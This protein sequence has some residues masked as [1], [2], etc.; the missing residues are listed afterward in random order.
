MYVKYLAGCRD[1][2]LWPLLENAA[3]APS[4][5]FSDLYPLGVVD[6]AGKDDDAED[7]E[8]DEEHELLGRGPEGLQ[9]NL[10]AGGVAGQL[11]QPEDA[12]DAEEL[13]DVGV[14]DVLDQLLQAEVR[15]EATSVT[16]P[17][18]FFQFVLNL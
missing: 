3:A 16:S 6:E 18:I 5:N 13:E 9:E 17:S 11:E 1:S 4:L 12:N 14:L 8:E 7:E 10:E 2:N 15:V